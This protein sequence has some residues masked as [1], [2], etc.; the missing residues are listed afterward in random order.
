MCENG[1]YFLNGTRAM[2]SLGPLTPTRHCPY[3]CAFCYV[4]DGFKKY[5][6]LHEDEILKFLHENSDNYNIIYVSGDTD[7][8]AKPRTERAIALL[9]RMSE[10]LNVD[11]LF[12]TRTVFDSEDIKRIKTIV[13]R[14]SSKKKRLYACIS[15]SRYSDDVAYIEPAPIPSPIDRIHTLI[16]LKK[17]GAVTVVALRPF[18]PVVDVSDYLLIL[19]KLNGYVDI[20]LGE[21]FYFSRVGKICKRVFPGGIPLEYEKD[22]LDNQPMP[23]NDNNIPWSVWNSENYEKIVQT[24]CLDKGIIF[25]MHSAEALD[26][27]SKQAAI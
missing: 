9:E 14:Q 7:S 22:I 15:I 12:T 26:L 4:Q 19:K 8:F 23:F 20:A 13:D 27:Y 18:L 2:I 25:S 1:N 5:S 6:N 17:I 10:E 21:T 11:L 3:S 16:D 24:Y